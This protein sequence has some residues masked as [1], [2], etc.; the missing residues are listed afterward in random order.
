MMD[1]RYAVSGDTDVEL[2]RAHADL[3]RPLEGGYG[4]AGTNPSALRCACKSKE[5]VPSG[6]KPPNI[7]NEIVHK[8]LKD[9]HKQLLKKERFRLRS[10]GSGAGNQELCPDAKQ[11][12]MKL[13]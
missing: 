5:K 7:S 10:T 12:W 11:S 8:P 2:Q 13:K 3:K 9:G 6:A 4:V 1:H